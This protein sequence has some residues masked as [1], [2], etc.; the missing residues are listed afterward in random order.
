MDTQTIMLIAGG[1][2]IVL[3]KKPTAQA[4]S[5]QAAAATLLN[6]SI[7]SGNV[8][9]GTTTLEMLLPQ[10]T[11]ATRDAALKILANTSAE[12]QATNQ[13]VEAGQSVSQDQVNAAVEDIEENVEPAALNLVTSLANQGTVPTEQIVAQTIQAPAIVPAALVAATIAAQSQL[14]VVPTAGTSMQTTTSSTVGNTKITYRTSDGII[15]ALLIPS[16][17][18]S[19]SESGGIVSLSWPGGG[20]TLPA[21]SK[22]LAQTTEVSDPI[23]TPTNPLVTSSLT[24]STLGVDV[25]DNYDQRDGGTYRNNYGQITNA[26]VLG[27]NYGSATNS[28]V[29]GRNLG[30]MIGGTLDGQNLGQRLAGAGAYYRPYSTPSL[31]AQPSFL[32]DLPDAMG[33]GDAEAYDPQHPER[34]QC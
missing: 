4:D 18:I 7:Q 6:E 9:P 34:C 23:G 17:S 31:G 26:V 30:T 1:A 25:A 19:V 10:L 27:D 14:L 5:L 21:G 32:R 15:H 20:R 2:A 8:L 24:P 12:T 16:R 11:G 3:S 29:R 13:L 33:L 22:V 28:H